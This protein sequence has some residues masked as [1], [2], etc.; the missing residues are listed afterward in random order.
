MNN[1]PLGE[2]VKDHNYEVTTNTLALLDAYQYKDQDTLDAL[3]EHI[4]MYE[5]AAELAR[6]THTIYGKLRTTDPALPPSL[7]NWL[8]L[9]VSDDER[10]KI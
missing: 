4:P 3:R 7:T 2:I 5:V 9:N 8:A 6:L 1:R 10:I